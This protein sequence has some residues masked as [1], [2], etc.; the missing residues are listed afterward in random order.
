MQSCVF[1]GPL[2]KALTYLSV[3]ELKVNPVITSSHESHPFVLT[4]PAH[5]NE[6]TRRK[7]YKARTVLGHILTIPTVVLRNRSW[8]G[9]WHVLIIS[10]FPRLRQTLSKLQIIPGW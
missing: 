2:F 4:D 8:L 5:M 6:R 9:I 1:Y 10:A 3:S 7:L